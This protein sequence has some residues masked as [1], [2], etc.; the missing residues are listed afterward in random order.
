MPPYDLDIEA[1]IRDLTEPVTLEQALTEIGFGS[2]QF[3]NTANASDGEVLELIVEATLIARKDYGLPGLNWLL[4]FPDRPDQPQEYARIFDLLKEL[5]KMGILVEFEGE[6]VW[7]VKPADDVEAMEY[8]GVWWDEEGPTKDE[9]FKELVS[10]P[11]NLALALVFFLTRHHAPT[12]W[13][14]TGMPES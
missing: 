8:C 12:F 13:G 10:D 14:V 9:G 6:T 3:C 2:S 11:E 7:Y 5:L 4:L 1:I